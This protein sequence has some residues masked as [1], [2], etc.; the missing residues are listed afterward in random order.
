MPLVQVSVADVEARV[1]SLE[2]AGHTVVSIT[3]G[4]PYGGVWVLYQRKP[5][6]P[7]KRPDQ[8]VET[9]SKTK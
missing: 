4:A 8:K 7:R 5:R 3:P 2:K 1:A 6:A 9:R